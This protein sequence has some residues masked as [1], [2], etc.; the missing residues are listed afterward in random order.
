ME[1]AF[2]QAFDFLNQ[3]WVGSLIGVAGILAGLFFSYKFS[4][5]SPRPAYQ[6]SYLTLLGKEEDNLPDEV[7]V[8]YQGS[9]VE[10]LTKS[11]I[12][13]WNDGNEVLERSKFVSSDPVTVAFPQGTNILSYH[14]VKPT[15]EVINFSVN[16]VLSENNSLRIEFDYLDPKDGAVIEILHDGAAKYPMITGSFM[17]VPKGIENYGSVSEPPP[18]NAPKYIRIFF[19]SNVMYWA[20]LS[21]GLFMLAAALIPEE[22]FT[23][24]IDK[25][26]QDGELGKFVLTG[27]ALLY[28]ILPAIL[29]WWRRRRFPKSLNIEQS[30]EDVKPSVEKVSKLRSAEGQ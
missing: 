17:G 5:K 21:V 3:G 26:D 19:R 30:N 6:R 10:R 14:V 12:V 1:V 25:R 28:T 23:R 20:A 15:R 18:V 9:K 27:L 2:K 7:E 22:V 16:K 13:F 24:Y 29:L 11:K 8:F 4:R